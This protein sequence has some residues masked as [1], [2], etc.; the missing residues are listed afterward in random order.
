MDTLETL[1]QQ[2]DPISRRLLLGGEQ[3]DWLVQELADRRRLIA[4]DDPDGAGETCGLRLDPIG[5]SACYG[6]APNSS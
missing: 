3:G 1:L 6:R 2:K 5:A 4:R